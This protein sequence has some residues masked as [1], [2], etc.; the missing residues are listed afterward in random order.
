MESAILGGLEPVCHV[1]WRATV[2]GIQLCIISYA[3][4]GTVHGC[5]DV[6]DS[7][8]CLLKWTAQFLLTYREVIS[9]MYEYRGLNSFLFCFW[10]WVWERL[11]KHDTG[12]RELLINLST[13]IPLRKTSETRSISKQ[14]RP[15]QSDGAVLSKGAA[16]SSGPSNQ[17][18]LDPRQKAFQPV[19]CWGCA[20]NSHVQCVAS[21][22]FWTLTG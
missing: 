14:T 22:S 4:M 2:C 11:Y 5:F 15:S 3:T 16:A 10:F 13:Y 9:A 19:L 20:V 1:Y 21:K 12:T 17:E 8:C 18:G 6:T 7:L